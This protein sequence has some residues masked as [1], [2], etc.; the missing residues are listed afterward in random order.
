MKHSLR[1]TLTLLSLF[2]VA[3]LIGLAVISNYVDSARSAQSGQLEWKELPSIGGM[4][5]ERP[6]L[7]PEQSIIYITAAIIVGTLLIYS[8]SALTP[9]SYGK[10]GSSSQ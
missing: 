6:E 1:I 5:I 2:I 7:T 9:F 4:Q 8:S 10:P 3:H